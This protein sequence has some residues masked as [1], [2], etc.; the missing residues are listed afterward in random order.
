[1]MLTM[2][3]K[4][5][6]LKGPSGTGKT[7][8]ISL[9]GPVM[10]F[11]ITE[12]RNPIG[13]DLSS[14]RF[15]SMSAQF[16][17]FL[18]RSGRFGCL[19]MFSG[20][21]DTTR[22]SEAPD[23]AATKADRR[24]VTLLEEFPNT[25]MRSSTALES[26]RETLSH[27]LAA[28][29]SPLTDSSGQVSPVVMIISET[30]FTTSTAISD[31]FTAH[32]LLGP[33][34]LTHPAVSV[35]EFN[36]IAPTFI[37]KALDLVV[38]KEARTSGRRRTPGPAVLKRLG[39][40]GDVRSAVGSL[41]FL[42]LRGDEDSE[43]SGRVAGKLKRGAKDSATMTQVEKES[44]EMVTR[45]EATLGIFHAVGKVV[46]NKRDDVSGRDPAVEPPSQPPDHLS[47]SEHARPKVSQV[48]VDTLID[49]TGTDTQTFIAA[50]HENYILSCE[51]PS[52]LDSVNGCIDVLSDCDVLSPDGRGGFRSG[53]IGGG[54]SNGASQGAATDSL[55]QGD[56]CFQIAVR[57]IL[58]ALPHPVKRRSQPSSM[59]G[60]RA[61]GRGGDA[62]KMF[63][64]T[65]LRLWRQAEEIEAL[66]DSWFHRNA[67]IAHDGAQFDGPSTKSG[68]VESWKAHPTNALDPNHT[69]P[70]S[71]NNNTPPSLTTPTNT[72]RHETILER[73]PYL[74][75]I[76][77]HRHKLNRPT[78]E[79]RQ[80]EKITQFRGID[81]QSD[82]ISE[83]EDAQLPALEPLWTTDRPA[84]VVGLEPRSRKGG[85]RWRRGEGEEGTNGGFGASLLAGSGVE[86]LVLSDDDIED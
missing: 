43:W 15:V 3:K 83:E 24:N 52:T 80:L 8:T 41:E 64:P 29:T 6:I 28:T 18:G 39:E 26:F 19:D 74:A 42:C 55:R 33:R 56:I 31:S 23:V 65:S 38:Q 68:G 50:L 46:Y 36:P 13:S 72:A 7:T 70:A 17:D 84:E 57:G 51:G 77:R 61:G 21:G 16:E 73:L 58:F 62:H 82:E 79:I 45:R 25:F 78:T 75:Q 48:S 71:P 60:V 20:S 22:V 85:G 47:E 30:L 32:R 12:W 54:Y 4:L 40:I 11:G 86:K 35:I 10:G 27:F 66:V 44:L 14:E 49:E 2:A 53:A 81:A 5:L 9:L 63:Y 67:N 69:P 59:N 34:I 37:T 76:S 1:M